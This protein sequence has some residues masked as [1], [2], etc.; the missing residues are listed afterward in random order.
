MVQ[1]W[2]KR[3]LRRRRGDGGV[4]INNEHSVINCHLAIYRKSVSDTGV[5]SRCRSASADAVDVAARRDPAARRP[6]GRWCRISLDRDDGRR[7]SSRCCEM[8]MLA[9]SRKHVEHCQSSAS[10]AVLV[11]GIMKEDRAGPGSVCVTMFQPDE[12]HRN[13]NSKVSHDESSLALGPSN[14]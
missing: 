6:S 8:A 9:A 13:Q 1:R 5:M 7:T 12:Y 3:A 10:S 14:Q 4:V 2:I 11:R